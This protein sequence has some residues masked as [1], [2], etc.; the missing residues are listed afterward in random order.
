MHDINNT[1]FRQHTRLAQHWSHRTNHKES[2]TL[3]LLRTRNVRRSHD[4]R[5]IRLPWISPL[6]FSHPPRQKSLSRENSDT[7]PLTCS[8]RQRC[9]LLI[10][11]F[12]RQLPQKW[13]HVKK[14]WEITAKPFYQSI[15]YLPFNFPTL[16]IMSIFST[17]ELEEGNNFKHFA[18]L[19]S[20]FYQ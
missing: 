20:L 9:R 14:R 17:F 7:Q 10:F 8:T 15:R 3:E 6:L 11:L 2:T 16:L 13:P 1:S 12:Y 19:I 18:V 5:V 4:P